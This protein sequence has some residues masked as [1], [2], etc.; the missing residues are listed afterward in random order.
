M[1]KSNLYIFMYAAVMVIIV[2]AVLSM[3]ATGLKP[4]QDKNEEIAKKLDILNTVEKGLAVKEAESKNNYVEAE[5]SKFITE[6]FVVNSQGDRVEGVDAFT[7][8]LKKENGKEVEER[9]LPVYLCTH[10]NGSQNYIF[11]VLGK[12]LWGPIWGYVALNQDFVSIAGVVFD[13]KGETPG[14]GAEINTSMFQDQFKGKKVF[15]SSGA[16]TSIQVNKAGVPVTESSVDAITGGTI[17]SKS[18]EEMLY[19]CLS[20]YESFINKQK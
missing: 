16:F 3:A 13:H 19:D 18:L 14:L 1:N 15:N 17:T 7:I 20:V 4:L 11:P 6:S 8:N 5:Y 12:G 2:A 9:T 10:E